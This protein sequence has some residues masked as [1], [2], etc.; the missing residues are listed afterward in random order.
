MKKTA[1]FS[2]LFLAVFGLTAGITLM[3]H[4]SVAALPGCTDQCLYSYYC[5]YDSYPDC[6]G[7]LPYLVYQSAACTGGPHNCPWLMNEPWGCWDGTLPCHGVG[8]PKEIEW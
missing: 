7:A 2:T 5:S 4:G 3:T 6:G 8:F 1:L